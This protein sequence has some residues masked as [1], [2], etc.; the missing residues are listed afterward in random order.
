MHTKTM[1]CYEQINVVMSYLIYFMKC[2]FYEVHII[3]QAK[4]LIC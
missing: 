2:I 4:S 1:M 3:G